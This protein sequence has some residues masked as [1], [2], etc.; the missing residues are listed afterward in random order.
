MTTT[1]R[2]IFGW[3]QEE[4]LLPVLEE[5]FGEPLQKFE[6]RYS[7]WDYQTEN[8]LI[9]LKSRMY[10]LTQDTYETWM[11][12]VC[13]TTEVNKELAIFYNFEQ[14][15]SLFYIIYDKEQ[16]DTYKIVKNR[17]GQSTYLVPKSDFTQVR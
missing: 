11:I 16:F 1:V 2:H 10:P 13:K 14:D 7:R 6:D 17:Y 5:L 8:Y 12:P 9:E 15:K 4:S 3:K